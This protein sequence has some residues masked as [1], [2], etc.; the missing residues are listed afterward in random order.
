[1][2]RLRFPTTFTI[3]NRLLVY[4]V[5]LVVLTA[6]AISAATAL[7]VAR[8]SRARVVASSSRSRR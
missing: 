7:I 4:F 8:E 6:V 3:R 5:C 2:A 1:M